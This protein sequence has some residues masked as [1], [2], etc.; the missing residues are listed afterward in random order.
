MLGRMALW[1]KNM[2]GFDWGTRTN[3]VR[4]Y[5]IMK[6]IVCVVSNSLLNCAHCSQGSAL[7]AWPRSLVPGLVDNAYTKQVRLC[8][9]SMAVSGIDNAEQ[10]R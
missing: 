1:P 9:Y 5:G 10:H 6:S 4:C 8:Q 7:H 2:F 3:G